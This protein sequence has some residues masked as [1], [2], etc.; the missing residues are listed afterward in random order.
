MQVAYNSMIAAFSAG[1]LWEEALEVFA[2]LASSGGVQ[3]S[4]S[5]NGVYKIYDHMHFAF[6]RIIPRIM[7]PNHTRES[8]P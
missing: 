3:M 8:Y 5:R 7:P 6:P 2:V 4:V 1:C